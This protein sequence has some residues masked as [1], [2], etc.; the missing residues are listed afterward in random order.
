MF[1]AL[2]FVGAACRHETQVQATP[3]DATLCAHLAAIGCASGAD[4]SCVHSV[5]LA[6]ALEPVPLACLFAA[7]TPAAARACGFVTCAP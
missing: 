1:F 5:A 6:R 4:A 3:D 2:A 7:T